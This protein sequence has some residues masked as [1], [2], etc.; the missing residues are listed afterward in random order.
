M[1]STFG[2]QPGDVVTSSRG[3]VLEGV[4]L[5][6]YPTS[7]DAVA[8][9]NVLATVTTNT[10]GR[11][12]Y[13][14]ATL[15]VVW[16]RTADGQVYS[17]EDPTANAASAVTAAGVAADAKIVTERGT[18]R[19]N[20]SIT[21]ALID[22]DALAVGEST[23]PR[24]T[25]DWALAGPFAGSGSMRGSQFT[26][27]KTETI[28]QVKMLTN[29]TAAGATP[30]L[31]RIGIYQVNQATNLHTLVASIPNDTTLFATATTAYT[32]TLSAP[33]A[34]VAGTRYSVCALVVSAFALNGFPGLIGHASGEASVAPA[35]TTRADGVT[36]LPASFTNAI[37]NSGL[38]YAVLLP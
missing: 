34:K 4:S 12:S 20:Q 8:G 36:D 7:A 1:S 29:G 19:A 10:L 11:W 38:T 9:T 17:V 13:T 30:T 32:R 35:L 26:A 14:H 31:C 15:A 21:Y 5:S 2:D 16:V 22:P 33:L 25:V 24:R 28:T 6:L 23:M 18:E 3:D 27:T 37:Q